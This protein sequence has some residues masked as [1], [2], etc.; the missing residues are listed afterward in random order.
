MTVPPVAP[1]VIGAAYIDAVQKMLRRVDAEE[2]EKL[3]RIATWVREAQ[4]NGKHCYMYCMGHLLP[5][6]LKTSEI[7]KMFTV[8]VW[9]AGFRGQTVPDD[10]YAEGDVCLHIGYQHPPRELLKKARAAGAKVGYVSVLSDRDYVK[11]EG[12]VWI[13]PMW[14]WPDACV[15]IP[16]YDIPVLPA[17]S[18]VNG[19]IAWEIFRLSS[20]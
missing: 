4:A 5:E 20:M 19:A 6:E 13:D 1:G 8:A 11:D 10:T 17:S 16:G 12:V 2:S 7:G 14:D 3:A 15:E 9:N 18:V